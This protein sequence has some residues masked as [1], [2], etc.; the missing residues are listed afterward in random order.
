MMEDATLEAELRAFEREE[1]KR[2]GLDG[3][4]GA[5]R[6][7]WTDPVPRNFTAGERA[8][9]TIL[10]C[11]LTMAHDLFMQSALRGIGYKVEALDV[12]DNDALQFGREFG[13]RGQC[14]PTYF[15]VGNL[16]K[17]LTRLEREGMSKRD[18]IDKHLFV[19]VGACG[20]CRF[21]TYVTEYRKALR[22]SGFEGFR[23]LLFQQTDAAQ[24]RL[25][26]ATGDKPGLDMN[27]AF[28]L[29][30]IKAVVVGDVLNALMYRIRP[31]EVEEGATDRAV[32][33]CKKIVAEA[34]E[35][36]R[37]LLPALWRCRRILGAV[38]VDRLR[39][40]PKV[41]II[42]E[43]W[44]MTT[45]GDGNY[46]MQRFLETEGAEV[47]VQAVTAWV[48]Y[49]LWEVEYDTR[50]RL[51]LRG[52]DRNRAFG[53]AGVD[54][55]RRLFSLA[56]ADKALRGFFQGVARVMGLRGYH[57][58]DMRE[59]AE[60][61]HAFYDN[62]LRGGEG[63]MEVGKLILNVARSKVNMTLSI[64]PFGCMPSSSVSDGVQSLITEMFPEGIFLP[65]ET[66][67]DGAVNVYSSVQMALFKARQQAQRE[68]ER[69]LAETG[70]TLEEMRTWV[71][72]HRRYRGAFHRSPHV[73]GCTAADLVYDAASARP[74]AAPVRSSLVDLARR[75]ATTL[76]P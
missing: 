46:A 25:R 53:L 32:A 51:E 71:A 5:E 1:R 22:D 21:G 47:D 13:N 42:G 10:V 72:R 65:V 29:Q 55:R 49:L 34:L 4:D 67:G 19:T 26:Q 59:I 7:H 43:F 30:M 73:L 38:Q 54:T 18:I 3:G 68:V 76:H 62:K 20:P 12:P 66:N 27:R 37:F 2:L 33:E 61:S 58:P 70:R 57:L 69:A 39:I 11:G 75:A 16:V 41:G 50:E 15:T 24:G 23:V 63:H 9:T 8:H 45:E 6:E 36:R 31:Y 74:K 56:V 48:L 14:N 64:K 40:K 17:H 28:F 35:R 52:A 44:A 60:V